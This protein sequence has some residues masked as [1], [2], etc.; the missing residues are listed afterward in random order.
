M[1]N[2]VGDIY[3]MRHVGFCN[4]LQQIG[5]NTVYYQVIA[6]AGTGA[7]DAEIALAQDNGVAAFY[8]A[9]M[10]NV[11]GWRGVSVQWLTSGDQILVPRNPVV[12]IANAGLGTYGTANLPANVSYVIGAQTANAGPAWRGRIYPFFPSVNG[13]DPNGEMTA[14]AEVLLAQLA[15]AFATPTLAGGGGNT[16]TLMPVLAHVKTKRVPPAPPL[17]AVPAIYI[18]QPIIDWLPRQKFGT[19]RRRGQ[20]GRLN[21][22]PF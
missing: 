14:A 5:I 1:A 11:S 13:S 19:I 8:K 4:A 2:N 12:S 10:A 21:P 16:N 3:R 20:Y 6:K 15:N 7:S 9:L 17:P 18:W 22:L